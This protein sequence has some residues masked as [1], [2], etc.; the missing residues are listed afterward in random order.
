MVTGEKT[1]YPCLSIVDL[2]YPSNRISTWV[3]RVSCSLPT[4]YRN[5]NVG[6]LPTF[7]KA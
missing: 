4:T 6:N 1:Y 3:T 5:P 7:Q 2:I